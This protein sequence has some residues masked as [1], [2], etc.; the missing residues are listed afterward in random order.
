[1]S[2]H[3]SSRSQAVLEPRKSPVQA[4]SA[5]SVEAIL[6]ATI[7]V[8]L[9]VGKERLTTTK[10]A[11]RAGVSVGT[12]YQY[13]PNKSA[14]LQAALKRHL[15]EVGDAVELICKEQ[16]G[17]TLRQMVTALVTAFLQAKMKDG[18]ASVA[19]Y[20]VSSDVD[21]AKIAR[22]MAARFRKAVVRMLASANEPLKTDPEIVA[23]MLE[24]MMV[25]VSRRM[26]ESD[27][28]EKQFEAIRPELIFAA[29][30]YVEAC[31]APAPAKS[32]SA[33]DDGDVGLSPQRGGLARS[34]AVKGS[35][36]AAQQ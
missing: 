5:A 26:L 24:G 30:A 31:S 29:C 32:A 15:G 17:K 33:K 19:L 12:L 27:A 2:S 16:K 11:V 3:L 8:L 20:S 35:K 6:E 28:P 7:Q 9:G 21:G 23:S 18:K 1:V 22:E 10:V 36:G 14:L 25:G 13:F 4:R 34:D